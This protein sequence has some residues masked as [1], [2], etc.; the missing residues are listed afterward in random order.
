LKGFLSL[1]GNAAP[2]K[3]AITHKK[4]A[5]LHFKVLKHLTYSP[6]LAPLEY[7]LFPNLKKHLKGRKFEH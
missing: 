4:W 7:Y 2:H 5:D 6:D 1:Q 3:V